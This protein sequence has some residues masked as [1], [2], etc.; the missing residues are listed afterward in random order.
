DGV[1]AATFSRLPTSRET[2]DARGSKRRPGGA[3]RAS[4]IARATFGLHVRR[5]P[6]CR[7]PTVEWETPAALASDRMLN[8]LYS[9]YCLS[10]CGLLSCMSSLHSLMITAGPNCRRSPPVLQ[11]VSRRQ[12]ETSTKREGESATR[13]AVSPNYTDGVRLGCVYSVAGRW[14]PRRGKVADVSST[15]E[16]PE[17]WSTRMVERGYTR[18]DGGAN[19]SALARK[20]ELAVET[21]RRVVHGIGTPGPE[22]VAALAELL[23]ADVED[24]TGQ[25]VTAGPYVPPPESALLTEPQREALTALIRAIAAGQRQR[26]G[27]SLDEA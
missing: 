24:W 26:A 25:H 6:E 11:D 15:R 8:R 4:S 9:M 14:R 18:R 27:E 23:G 10:M 7:C 17:P 12:T 13:P 1:H 20:A 22:T 21:V 3:W 5:F 16:V 19:I 2:L